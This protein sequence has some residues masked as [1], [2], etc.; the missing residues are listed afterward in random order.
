MRSARPDQRRDLDRAVELDD[1]GDDAARLQVAAGDLGE[2]GRVA[3][4]DLRRLV[5][6]AVLGL[7]DDHAAAAD[8]EVERLVEIAVLLLQHVA[9]RDAEVGGAV[10]D[11]GGHVG[12]AHDQHAQRRARGSG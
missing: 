3:Q 2:L 6:R 4:V 1:L 11:V 9:P 7:G 12:V 5:D 10:L 8:A